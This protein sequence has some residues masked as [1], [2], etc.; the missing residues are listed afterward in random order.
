MLLTK[1]KVD[2]FG[3]FCDREIILKPGINLIYGENE[4]GKST[5]HTFIK[6]M[7][8]GIDRL[9]GR[10]AASK[11]DIY[12]RYLP[13]DYPGAYGGQM[14]IKVGE[15]A[16]RL[17]RSFHANN[18]NFN[19]IDLETGREVKL[20]EG[21]ISELI[22]GLTESAFRNTISIEQLR[23]KTDKELAS[24]LR[25]YITNLTIAKS[26]EVNVEKAVISLKQKKK[27]LESSSYRAE[28]EALR[29]KIEEGSV[30]EEK[31][32]ELTA[33]LR[34]LEAEED[35][36]N[37]RLHTLKDTINQKEDDLLKEL[38]A[39]LEKYRIY[40]EFT[41]Q[42]MQ[43]E[44]QIQ[45]IKDKLISWELVYEKSSSLQDDF[46][47]AQRLDTNLLD[48]KKNYQDLYNDQEIDIKNKTGFLYFGLSTVVTLLGF[49]FTQSLIKGFGIFS[50][51]FILGGL[52]FFFSKRKYRS[53]QYKKKMEI[54]KLEHGYAE[55]ESQLKAIFEKYQVA[56]LEE[57]LIMHEQYLKLTVSVEH[58]RKLLEELIDRRKALEDKCDELHDT[59]MLYMRNFIKEE[60]LT[61]ASIERLQNIIYSR[62]NE[63][64]EKLG[65]IMSKLGDYRLKIE[66]I[67]WELS[68]LEDNES[69]LIKNKEQYKVLEQKQKENELEIQ[70][71][72]LA[73]DTIDELSETIH[74]SFGRQLNQAV[75]DIIGKVTNKRYQDLKI[76]ERLKIKL[77]CNDNYIFLDR[78]SAGTID[79]V[80]F[81]L[82][83][84]VADMLLGKDMPLLLDDSFAL[85]D[86]SRVKAVLSE[87]SNRRQILIF[88]CQSREKQILE[89]LGLP[90]NFIRL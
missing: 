15:K 37:K 54:R 76:D 68:L 85:Y 73:L 56:S 64:E 17:Q 3:K 90:F 6:G 52:M 29:D 28:L 48:Y 13:W 69:E 45:E 77:E 59:I 87:I 70:A 22:P 88:T 80:Y 67:R 51:S 19:I 63:N 83:L 26:R 14:D 44:S 49:Y 34:G 10:G 84:A 78:L 42:Y 35:R 38:P 21:H 57:L 24:H 46:Y 62:R 25:N 30:N 18:R 39:I 8:F 61:P 75:S 86:D 89:E 31:V 2:Y 81:A 53:S 40:Q 12:T 47:K 16:Y 74:D 33:T 65:N 60:E 71:I 27:A 5:L 20:K 36:L 7:L 82:R 43:A 50:I 4:A 72:D 1:L 41:R 9:R 11:E 55:V 23:A 58:D 66:K 79:Q 32:D